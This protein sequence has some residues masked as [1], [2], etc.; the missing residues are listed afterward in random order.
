MPKEPEPSLP[1]AGRV[2]FLTRA[3]VEAA[4]EPEALLDA[5]AEGFQA[6]SSGAVAAPP[7]QGID[8]PDGA[9]LTMPGRRAGGPVV[10]K[11]VG[12]FAGNA[13]QGL[14]THPAVICLFDAT[15]GHCLAVMDGG[16][17]HARRAPRGGP[18]GR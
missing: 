18:Q 12:L 13:A 16:P 8:L 17:T 9:F 14:D 15:T 4:L 10:V 6:L 5:V 3:D 2:L 1:Y 7:R 11:L